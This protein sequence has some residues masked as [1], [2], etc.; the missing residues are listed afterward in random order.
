MILEHDDVLIKELERSL[1]GSGNAK[2][3]QSLET[4]TAMEVFS[5]SITK[6]VL[7]ELI[8]DVDTEEDQNIRSNIRFITDIPG[9]RK[10]LAFSRNFRPQTN[11]D[12]F[13][14]ST[15]DREKIFLIMKIIETTPLS[16]SSL[17]T[18]RSA[19]K[20]WSREEIINFIN[21]ASVRDIRKRAAFFGMALQMVDEKI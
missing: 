16:N 9:Q 12:A 3:Y 11:F 17:A 6:L 1:I 13:E 2:L 15:L 19:L 20:E 18:A 5:H 21:R 7:P 4:E 10:A 14:V 8:P